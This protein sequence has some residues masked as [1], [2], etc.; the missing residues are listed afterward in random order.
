MKK[1][2]ILFMAVFS[3]SALVVGCSSSSSSK[4]DDETASAIEILADIPTTQYFTDDTIPDEDLTTI[5]NSGINAPSG[6]NNQPWHFSV[7]TDK[8]VMSKIA[9]EMS[10]NMPEGAKASNKAGFGDSPA[11]II[12]SAEEG[13]ELEAGI[14][15]EAMAS[16][17]NVLGYGTKIAGSPLTVLNG[18]NQQEYKETLGIPDNQIVMTTLMIGKEDKAVDTTVDGYTGATERNASEELVTYIKSDNN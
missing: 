6:M 13:S 12:I 15:C 11:V 8:D 16:T 3:V 5:V 2:F 7:L 4:S 10:A 1:S 18:E 14:A 9:D 17:A